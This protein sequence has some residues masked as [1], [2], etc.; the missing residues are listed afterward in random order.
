MP[1]TDIITTIIDPSAVGSKY[2]DTPVEQLPITLFIADLIA[3]MNWDPSQFH[4]YRNYYLHICFRVGQGDPADSWE[5][6]HGTI[7][8]G[9]NYAYQVYAV[10]ETIKA[11]GLFN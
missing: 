10:M 5:Q 4:I 11:H 2:G 7:I 9:F 6:D 8:H 3:R 1:I